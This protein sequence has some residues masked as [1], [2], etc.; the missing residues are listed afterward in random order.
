M[1]TKNED[2]SSFSPNIDFEGSKF[3]LKNEDKMK[4]LKNRNI[5][6]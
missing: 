2:K 6:I 3:V 5:K 4:I 1:G